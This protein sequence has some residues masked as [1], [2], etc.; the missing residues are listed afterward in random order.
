[1]W[2]VVL[3]FISMAGGQV[4]E[5]HRMVELPSQTLELPRVMPLCGLVL[6]CSWF[7]STGMGPVV[8]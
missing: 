8:R 5:R 6:S 2:Q 1:M 7:L 3:I 4:S